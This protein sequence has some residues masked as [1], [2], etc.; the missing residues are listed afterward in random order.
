M[1][2]QSANKN[3]LVARRFPQGAGATGARLAWWPALICRFLVMVTLSLAG[4]ALAVNH[5]VR[6]QGN[7]FVPSGLSVMESTSPVGACV[8]S[9]V[10]VRSSFR[11]AR[12]A[13]AMTRTSAVITIVELMR[14]FMLGSEGRG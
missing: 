12:D 6:M 8:Y 2:F 4:E 14:C 7:R 9:H 5:V 1:T 10:P 3:R 11:S 13:V